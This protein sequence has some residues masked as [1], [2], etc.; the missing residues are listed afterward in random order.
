L[1]E[2]G[3]K[4]KDPDV[5]QSMYGCYIQFNSVPKK[6]DEGIAGNSYQISFGRAIIRRC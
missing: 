6:K 5:S 4:R 2:N 1:W 3:N